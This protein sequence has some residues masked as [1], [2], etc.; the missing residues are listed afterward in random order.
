MIGKGDDRWANYLDFI[1]VHCLHIS[2]HD[3]VSHKCMQL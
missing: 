3:T 1:M 2:K